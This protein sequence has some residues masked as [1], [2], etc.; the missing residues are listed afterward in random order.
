[1]VIVALHLGY[2]DAAAYSERL[3]RSDPTL[4]VLLLTDNGVYVPQGM[5]SRD[6]QT[7]SPVL[8]MKEIGELLAGSSHIREIRT[9][10]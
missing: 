1:M 5:L 2:K 8:L 4:P 6:I 3:H 9:T 10:V 7:G